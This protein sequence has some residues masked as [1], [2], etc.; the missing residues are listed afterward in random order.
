MRDNKNSAGGSGSVV[1]SRKVG[2]TMKRKNMSLAQQQVMDSE[3]QRA[4][5]LYREMKEKKM[6]KFSS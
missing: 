5:D 6:S 2:E 3:R 1:H 4:I